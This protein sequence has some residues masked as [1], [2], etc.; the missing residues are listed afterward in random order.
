[1]LKGYAGGMLGRQG[2]DLLDR[3]TL[4]SMVPFE[5]FPFIESI[6]GALILVA[7]TFVWL[8]SFPMG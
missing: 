4:S 1:M 3:R 6:L 2:L 5:L 8:Q 7:E